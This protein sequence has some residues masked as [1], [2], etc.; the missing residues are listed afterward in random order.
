ML[1]TPKKELEKQKTRAELMQYAA[2]L[3]GQRDYFSAGLFNKLQSYALDH[4]DADIVLEKMVELNYV[5]DDRLIEMRVRNAAEH[6]SKGPI[7]IRED[8]SSKGAPSHLVDHHLALVDHEIW[9]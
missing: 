1:Y 5:N 9:D 2:W 8:L 4:R 3:L 7:W 6:P